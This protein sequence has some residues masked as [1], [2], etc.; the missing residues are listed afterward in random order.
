[1]TLLDNLFTLFL[2]HVGTLTNVKTTSVASLRRLPTSSVI[3]CP[4]HRNTHLGIPNEY[5]ILVD[6]TYLSIEVPESR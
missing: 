4:H 3:T 2:T 1:M 6:A 5:D